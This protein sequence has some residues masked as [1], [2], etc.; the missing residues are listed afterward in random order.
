MP[1]ISIGLLLEAD[2]V[3]IIASNKSPFVNSYT[4]PSRSSEFILEPNLI[5][6][7]KPFSIFIS[8]ISAPKTSTPD[9]FKICEVSCPISPSPITITFEPNWQFASLTPCIAIAPTVV[10]EASI[11]STLSGILTSRFL[12]IKTYSA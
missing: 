11:T 6:F 3:I 7:S 5:P 12:G 8:S 2:A 1:A 9:A 10:N 4:L